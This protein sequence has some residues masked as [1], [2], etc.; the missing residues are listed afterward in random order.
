MRIGVTAFLSDRS[1]RPDELARAAEERGF[2]SMYVPEH[3]HIP[4]SRRTPAPMG[5]PL[6]EQYW[7][8]LDPFVA[9]TAAAAVTKTL[10]LGTGVSLV[11]EHDPIVL[12][13]EI[14]TLDH[15]SGGR[16]T[17]GLGFGWNVEEAED[18]RVEWKRRRAI[19]RE[20]V[21][22]MQALWSNDVAGFDGEFVRF[23]PSKS[24]PKP[25]Q[26]PRPPTLIGGGAGPIMFKH[27]A[28]YADG[29]APIGARGV[30][31]ALPDL[32]RAWE[33]A[34]RDPAAL[35][36]MPFGSVPDVGKLEYFVSLGVTETVL[37]LQYGARDEV[38]R[39]LDG[40]ATIVAEF[41]G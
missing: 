12:A 25:V 38:L 22:A 26:Q 13:K 28:E 40:F 31:K 21:L 17:F 7:R 16:F 15:L 24:W 23:E 30:A 39:E 35:Q 32:K 37:G 41:R 19:T 6:P 9:L 2:D 3:T 20:K 18:H 34:G 5:E 4:V 36:L 29:W 33:D 8:A 1:I 11:M 10:R 14:A 27:I